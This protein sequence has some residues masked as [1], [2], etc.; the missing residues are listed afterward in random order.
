MRLAILPLLLRHSTARAIACWLTIVFPA[1]AATTNWVAYNDHTPGTTAG[2]ATA[3]NATR[4]NM[5]GVAAGNAGTVLSGTLTNFDTG[6]QLTAVF[7]SSRITADPDDFG[8]MSYPAAGT[9]AYLLFNGKVDLGNSQSGIGIRA[10]SGSQTRLTFSNLD[11]AKRYVFRGTSVRGGSGG[12]Y[13]RRWT[14]CTL[15]DAPTFTDSHTAGVFTSAN[16]PTGTMTPGQ[17]A[18][19]AGDNVADGAVVG[20]TSIQPNASGMFSVRCQQYADNPLPNGLTPA[21]E[22]GYGI[23][24]MMLA[25][26][27]TGPPFAPTNQNVNLPANRSVSACA[28]VSL[29]TSFAGSPAPTYLW[30]KNNVAMDTVANP[31]AAGP[32]LNLN[33]TQTSDSGMYHVV[34]SNPSGTAVSRDAV[35]TVTAGPPH[36][37]SVTALSSNAYNFLFTFDQAID[38]SSVDTFT[39]NFRSRNGVAAWLGETA[40]TV[41]QVSPTNVLV[42]SELPREPL[43]N[44]VANVIAD[45]GIVDTCARAPLAPTSVN[46][47]T[48]IA[49]SDFDD[50]ADMWSYEQSGLDLGTAWR[51]PGY[52]DSAWLLGAAFFGLET[53]ANVLGPIRTPWTIG[54]AQLTYYL[55]KSANL[56]APRSEIVSLTLRQQVDDG[57]VTYINGLEVARHG[58]TATEVITNGSFAANET[59]PQALLVDVLSATNVVQGRNYIAVEVHQTS[60][61]SSDV[62]YGSK[63]TAITR[64][65]YPSLSLARSGNTLTISWPEYGVNG[66][67]QTS[68]DLNTWVT[69]GRTPALS[70]GT[71]RLTYTIPAGAGRLFIRFLP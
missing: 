68:T 19:M 3:P 66:R 62:L 4:Y 35:V 50:A 52:D 48:E 42:T 24:A 8:S 34:V 18:Y 20:W 12:T 16:F 13:N 57:S 46:V 47:F 23:C 25:E 63:L 58:F 2:W 15:E 6:A 36:L 39:I 5:R 28:N 1:A 31:S 67:L 65:V 37:T 64:T 51:A 17:A 45:S 43:V 61:S 49:L 29:T 55:R 54:A 69:D 10:S 70:G 40:L 30:Y 14:L 27:E 7:T 21:P 71:Y 41:L 22:Y 53:P 38:A 56:P 26:I 60:T 33:N 59:E 32:V 9:P 44:Y 11:P